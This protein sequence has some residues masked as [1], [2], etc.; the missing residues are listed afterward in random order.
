MVRPHRR[1]RAAAILLAV[2]AAV[3]GPLLVGTHDGYPQ[4]RHR[5][6]SGAAWLVSQQ[7]GQLTL[8]DGSSA[9]VAAQV[10]VADPGAALDVAQQG[11]TAYAV[12][13][14]RGTLRRVDGAT[15][16]VGAPVQPLPAARAG[17]RAFPGPGVVYALDA[18]H[19]VLAET[20]PRTLLPRGGQVPLSARVDGPASVLDGAGRLWVLDGSA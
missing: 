11:A 6:S 15:F 10:K 7:V 20:D 13:G 16:E 18:E 5:L 4:T 2:A 17:L 19:G 9:E 3:G 12:D 1:L 8:L 14:S